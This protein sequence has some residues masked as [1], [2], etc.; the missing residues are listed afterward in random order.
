[1]SEA[2]EE[3]AGGGSV[4]L[5]MRK[6]KR[7]MVVENDYGQRATVVDRTRHTVTLR[8]NGRMSEYSRKET[9]ENWKVLK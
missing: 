2:Q 4:I 1:M 5:H 7:G 3:A 8:Y 9:M 6:L